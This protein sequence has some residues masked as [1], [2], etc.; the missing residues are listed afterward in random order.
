MCFNRKPCSLTHNAV[1]NSQKF[2]LNTL[3]SWS[4]MK[5]CLEDGAEL[6]P[7]PIPSEQE[8][9]ALPES[10]HK[11]HPHSDKGAF[12]ALQLSWV[13]SP[14]WLQKC[15]NMEYFPSHFHVPGQ[16]KT[17]RVMNDSAALWRTKVIILMHREE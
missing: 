8:G 1:P 2:Q 14:C 7:N 4:S 17:R 15:W 6:S 12:D 9:F 16:P 3:F 13:I 10:W 5:N 11:C